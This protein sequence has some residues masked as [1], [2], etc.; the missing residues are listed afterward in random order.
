MAQNQLLIPP[1]Q[2]TQ[3]RPSTLTTVRDRFDDLHEIGPLRYLVG[4]LWAF[5]TMP[6]WL[7]LVAI[8]L[9]VGSMASF[10]SLATVP[11]RVLIGNSFSNTVDR[12][13]DWMVQNW[14]PFFHAVNVGLL[15]YLLLPLEH[16]LQGLPWWLATAVVAIA[17]Y[18]LN[19]ATF[20]VVGTGLMVLLVALGLYQL[21]MATLA[22]VLTATLLAVVL[23]V[24]VG[25]I[26]A[27]SQKADAILR[28]VLDTMQTM[29]T[30]VYLIPVLMLFGLGKVPAVLATL[31]YPVPPIIRLTGLGIRQVDSSVVE[32]AKAFG[33]TGWQLLIKV[34]IPPALPTIM[35]GLNQTIMMALAMV[36]I[37]SM[38]GAKTLGTEVL[39]G[40]ARLEVG[41]G[42]LGGLGIVIMTIILDRITQGIGKTRRAV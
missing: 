39:N 16:W 25:I 24:P 22:I 28:P 11:E 10:G 33:A 15:Q 31:I 38:I 2:Q 18:R 42:L 40:I 8:M 6:R 36:V 34:Q 12:G 4:P 20:T 13:V 3:D 17:A 9:I 32:A 5:V 19:G 37:A 23:G 21:A 26:A 29:P 14:N 1:T 41:R 27:R 35:A 7:Q 30:F